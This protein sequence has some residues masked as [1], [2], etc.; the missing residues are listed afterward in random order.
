MI[1]TPIMCNANRRG[2]RRRSAEAVIELYC[3]I[4]TNDYR[5]GNSHTLKDQVGLVHSKICEH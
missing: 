2:A 5:I 4:V 3:Q 1:D